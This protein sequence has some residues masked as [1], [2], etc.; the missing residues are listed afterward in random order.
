MAQFTHILSP[1]DGSEFAT[2]ALR[3]AAA[4]ARQ[5][6]A[7]LTVLTARPPLPALGIWTAPS[8]AKIAW[9]KDPD[10]NTLSLT[11]F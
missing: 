1:V 8:G 9:F 11:Q 10:G 3:Y 2:R 7:Q 5:G 4:L 6:N